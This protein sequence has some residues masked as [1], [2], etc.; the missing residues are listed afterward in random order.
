M[1]PFTV[2]RKVPTSTYESEIEISWL[3]DVMMLKVVI[4][5]NGGVDVMFCLTAEE[6]LRLNDYLEEA[7]Q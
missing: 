4:R 5:D 1:K 2:T 3:K 7:V 6:V